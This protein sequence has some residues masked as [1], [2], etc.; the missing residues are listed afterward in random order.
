MEGLAES[1]GSLLQHLSQS[2]MYIGCLDTGINSGANAH[3]NA[4]PLTLLWTS[5]HPVSQKAAKN[6]MR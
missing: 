4:M 5:S 1:N 2:H 6:L 3:A